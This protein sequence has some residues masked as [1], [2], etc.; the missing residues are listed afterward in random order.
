MY[1]IRNTNAKL[2]LVYGLQIE[3]L[4]YLYI[5]LCNFMEHIAFEFKYNA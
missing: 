5:I 1:T 3:L 2:M 4:T